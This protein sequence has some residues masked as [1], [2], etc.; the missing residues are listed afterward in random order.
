MAQWDT[1]RHGE[2]ARRYSGEWR[3]ARTG[4]HRGL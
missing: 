4:E 3:L 2:L 1:A